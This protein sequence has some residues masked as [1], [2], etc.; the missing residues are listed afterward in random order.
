MNKDG[1]YALRVHPVVFMALVTIVCI[2]ITS[3]LFLSTSERVESNELFFLR[4]SVLDAASIEHDGTVGG[5]EQAYMKYVKEEGE[6]YII[7]YTDGTNAT[8][9]ERTGA[10]LWGPITIV[11]GFVDES[12]LSGVSILSQNETPGLGARIEEP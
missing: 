4:R 9:V 5:V 3:A 1:F 11:V 10:G 7:T 8:V 12:T 2:L 6:K